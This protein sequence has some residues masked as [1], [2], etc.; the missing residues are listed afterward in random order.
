MEVVTKSVYKDTKGKKGITILFFK[1][2]INFNRCISS[3]INV[4]EFVSLC[5]G[6]LLGNHPYQTIF[7]F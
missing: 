4:L 5:R 6:R 3:L 2:I 7:K 1:N